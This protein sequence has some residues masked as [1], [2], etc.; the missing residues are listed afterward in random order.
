MYEVKS[1]SFLHNV[2]RLLRI[3]ASIFV[4][5]GQGNLIKALWIER[6]KHNLM[7]KFDIY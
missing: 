4:L 2:N 1:E 7:Y 6:R 5:N 3:K